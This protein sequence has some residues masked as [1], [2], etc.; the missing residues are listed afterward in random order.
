MKKILRTIKKGLAILLC[1]VATYTAV[2]LL[3]YMDDIEHSHPHT[4]SHDHN[5][6]CTEEHGRGFFQRLFEDYSIKAS[7]T[8]YGCTRYSDTKGCRTHHWCNWGHSF[9][10]YDTYNHTYVY[11]KC[12]SCGASNGHVHSYTR[13][14]GAHPHPVNMVCSCGYSYISGYVTDSNCSS[15]NPC[16]NGHSFG[17]PSYS[18]THPHSGHYICSRCGYQTYA[19][20]TTMSSCITCN[21]CANGHD[22][23]AYYCEAEHP[24]ANYNYCKRCAYKQ[25]DGTNRYKSNCKQCN[26][27]LECK[28]TG[29]YWTD[30]AHPHPVYCRGCSEVIQPIT[31][32]STCS[33]CKTE[34]SSDLIITAWTELTSVTGSGILSIEH[35]KEINDY[36]CYEVSVTGNDTIKSVTCVGPDGTY[37][38]GYVPLTSDNL[39]TFK[40]TATTNKG[41]T[42]TISV[43]I[44]T[45]T[46]AVGDIRYRTVGMNVRE[47]NGNNYFK[48]VNGRIALEGAS[49][50]PESENNKIAG[51]VGRYD[52]GTY[53][54]NGSLVI[55]VSN[56]K[57][58]KEYGE[59]DVL[60]EFSALT[61]DFG[62]GQ[63]TL[64]DFK[65]MQNA[66]ITYQAPK[67]INATAT[68]CSQD[69]STVF[70]SVTAQQIGAP[71]Y[72]FP[73]QT[74]TAVFTS[75]MVFVPSEWQ[76][77]GVQWIYSPQGNGYSNGSA[78]GQSS[79]G[80]T[81]NKDTPACSFYFYWKEDVEEKPEEQ[82]EEEPQNEPEGKMTGSIKVVA[83]DT[84]TGASI[85]NARVS[86][87][88]RSGGNETIF[89][90]LSFGRYS[91]SA[92]APGYNSGNGSATISQS[93]PDATISIALQKI[94][95]SPSAEMDIEILT[96]GVYRKGSTVIV[97]AICSSDCDILP[98]NPAT[99]SLN[100]T[101]K[102]KSGSGYGTTTITSQQKE[103]IIPEGESNLVWFEFTLP[104]SEY[105]S[106]EISLECKITPPEDMSGQQRQA[107]KT[108]P[109]SD[110][111]ARSSPKT[112]FEKS[113]PASF[114]VPSVPERTASQLTW[115]VWEWVD[116]SFV[117]NTY[118]ASLNTAA[119]LV[120]DSTAGYKQY[121]N[122]TGLWTTRS[123]YGLN[124]LL[125][126]SVNNTHE[127]VTGNAKADVFYPEYSYS[128][129]DNKSNN[130]LLQSKVLS[131][132]TLKYTFSFEPNQDTI[133]GNKMHKTPIWYPDGRYTIEYQIFDIWTPGG[134]LTAVDHATIIIDGN[135]YDDSYIQPT[136]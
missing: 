54:L 41:A 65:T 55:S 31:T 124:T 91:A 136:S 92:S 12:T 72:I 69:K 106:D 75:N 100:A 71:Q 45:Q 15:C 97:S 7:A 84:S 19:G 125:T 83:Y 57:T 20:Q 90:G 122:A 39:G 80:V 59:Y 111:I 16:R 10:S 37:S 81:F 30:T 95:Q 44:K 63:S 94:Q 93:N 27:E 33:L 11:G 109:V 2:P 25:Y 79:V 113:A 104:S 26:P 76:Y 131:G 5:H 48:A 78:V 103:V 102:K 51:M 96:N 120:P 88:G 127:A 86:L 108:I 50:I 121:N 6:D 40:I 56:I 29:E 18:T 64:Q 105:Y 32:L 70:G 110:Y 98:T 42:K 36:F 68:Y 8:T 126:V 99:V 112:E 85:P 21:P 52:G 58:G 53:T 107:N 119:S 22:Y 62:W 129:S 4:H 89:S 61:S 38:G 66:D 28:H 46:P 130:L 77:H 134:E 17:A 101:Y 3:N 132:S 24:H 49:I 23:Y 116:N 114:R 82:P 34:G 123:G 135:M 67:E 73:Y 118:S 9:H 115:E 1:L 128:E 43:T 47:I 117:K 14:V 35:A 60:T 74:Y 13:S 87:G 133:S